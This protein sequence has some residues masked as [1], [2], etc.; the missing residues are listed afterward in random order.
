MIQSARPPDQ[1][2]G[3]APPLGRAV[4]Q[5]RLE[6]DRD[7]HD[8]PQIPRAE[9][10]QARQAQAV[11][12][13]VLRPPAAPGL[14]RRHPAGQPRRKEQDDRQQDQRQ[15]PGHAPDRRLK[16]RQRQQRRAQEEAQALDRVLRARQQ[17][18]P[19]EQPAL[20]LRRQELDRGFR[21]HL[22][23][24]LGHARHPPAL[25]S[26]TRPRPRRPNPDQ[27]APAPPARRSARPARRKASP[28]ARTAPQAT[29]P[30]GWSRSPRPRTAGTARP[31][32]P[33]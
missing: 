13:R 8:E 3:R 16:P 17:R 23:Q 10:E 33:G 27:A 31:A 5:D 19:A 26:R 32:G 28:P 14:I 24:V 7:P 6:I 29:R 30:P 12:P 22:G 15:H 21:G 18:H 4:R 2:K 11:H 25:P 1:E 9:Q 20:P